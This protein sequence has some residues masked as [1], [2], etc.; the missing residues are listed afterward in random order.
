MEAIESALLGASDAAT[1]LA[2][3]NAKIHALVGQ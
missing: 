2:D 3:A 1:A